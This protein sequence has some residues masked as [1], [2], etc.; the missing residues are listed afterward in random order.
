MNELLANRILLTG[1]AAWA[2]AQ[3]IKMI[4]HTITT[5]T[6]DWRRLVGDGGMPSCHS[7]TVTATALMTGF[8]SGFNSPVFAIA[9]ILAIIVMH[10]AMG[11]RL[12]TGKQA[13]RLN[14]MAELFIHLGEPS[15]SFDTKLK[16][17]VG[18]TPM[19]VAVGFLLGII[20]AIVS[21]YN[22]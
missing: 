14:E 15:L 16:E 1:V 3:L 22:F 19:Q 6:L 11:V 12:E 7:S 9:T 21:F 8:E 13:K 2:V 17:F 4:I 20:V 5:R 18:H 10:D